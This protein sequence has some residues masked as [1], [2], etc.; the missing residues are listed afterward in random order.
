MIKT[1]FFVS[2]VAAAASAIEVKL[3]SCAS[4]L[5]DIMTTMKVDTNYAEGMVVTTRAKNSAKN[6]KE[7]AK[8]GENEKFTDPAMPQD[9]NMVWWEGADPVHL[10]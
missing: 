1:K 6:M 2:C 7:L 4:A 5:T 10:L 9:K 3:E 8:V